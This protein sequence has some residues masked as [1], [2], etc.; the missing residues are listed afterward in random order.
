MSALI[1]LYNAFIT[2]KVV[3]VLGLCWL[4]V[5]GA[6]AAGASEIFQSSLSANGFFTMGAANQPN[7]LHHPIHS[8]YLRTNDFNFPVL[9]ST[10]LALPFT[11]RFGVE[12]SITRHQNY[13]DLVA[14]SITST[15]DNSEK[16]ANRYSFAQPMVFR[17][18]IKGYSLFQSEDGE[19]HFFSFDK[20]QERELRKPNLLLSIT[21]HF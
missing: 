1:D 8:Q 5:I 21:K 19:S 13:S 16:S 17:I 10:S 9:E 15:Q 11:D 18:T 14:F 3:S 7:P 6:S 2:R 12:Y 4:S 20:A